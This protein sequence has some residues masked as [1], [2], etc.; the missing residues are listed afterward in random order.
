MRIDFKSLAFGYK[1][2]E[3]VSTPAWETALGQ[4]QEY[5]IKDNPD[6]D[7]II[8]GM[9][10]CAAPLDKIYTKIG[11]PT[12]DVF[13]NTENS[14]ILLGSVFTKVYINDILINNGKFVLLIVK[15]GS[16]YHSGRLKLKYS[17]HNT[18]I[19]DNEQYS[20]EDF[21][22]E[23]RSQLG[24]AKESCWFVYDI[25]VKNQD[26]LILKT[27]IVNKEGSEVYKNSQEHHLVWDNLSH[28]KNS[29]VSKEHRNRI[30]YGAPGTGKSYIV[31]KEK[32]KL[33][34]KGGFYER[35]TFH[36][37]YSYAQFVGTYKPVSDGGTISYNYV[38][39]PFI[40]ILEKAINNPEMPCLLIIEEINRANPAAVFGDVFQLL[41]RKE[42]ESE[43]AVHTSEDL[44]KYLDNY[45]SRYYETSQMKIPSNMFIWAT[46]N[47][48]DQGVFPMDTAFKR[49][50]NFEYLDINNGED[51][52]KDIKV[53][54][55][56]YGEIIWNDLRK[57]INGALTKSN[58]NEDKLLGP[59]F[60]SK[61]NLREDF[62]TVFRNKVLMYLFE[63]AAKQRRQT[64]FAGC[65]E[66]FN[67][68]S[69]ICGKFNTD[70]LDIFGTEIADKFRKAE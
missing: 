62:N 67:V 11:N 4:G 69:K 44:K 18:Y 59:H 27:I 34:E 10:H 7:E 8:K 68:F 13:G 51:D 33:L 70:G 31:E 60:L 32:E 28:S 66:D 17:R 58:I 5:K 48:A 57:A 64:I 12:I 1:L 16:H 39:G 42:N 26:A 25:S 21:F 35:V 46:M 52:I 22:N 6:I 61:E 49:R 15:D 24:L 36:P 23:V 41:D 30:I 14:P 63:D 2:E 54:V 37:D 47:S 20:N 29:F 38:P 40:R 50:W 43:Y 19:G 53:E 56:K 3:G 65:K 55:P 45:L 9:I